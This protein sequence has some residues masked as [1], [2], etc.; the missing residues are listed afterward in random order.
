MYLVMEYIEL[1][2][3][4]TYLNEH[5]TMHES[6]TKVV[7]AQ[8]LHGIEYI[9][10][11]GISHRDLKPDNILISQMNP[12][13]IK[14]SDFGLAKMIQNENTFLKTFCG[15]MLY[16]AP[17]V[18]PAYIMLTQESRPYDG[19]EKRKRAPN[20]EAGRKISKKDRKPYNQAVDMW[21]FGC[22][23]FALLTGA[24]P[25][26]GK[27][28]DEMFKMVTEG[29]FDEQ[30]L[31]Q[32]VGQHNN[33]C[34]DF[35]RRVLQVRPE[36]RMME[37]EA[38]KHEWLRD[39]SM[40]SSQDS[41]EY[42]EDEVAGVG[43]KPS[44][45]G[46]RIPNMD[47]DDHEDY[48]DDEDVESYPQEIESHPHHETAVSSS[49][50][51]GPQ[52]NVH[53]QDSMAQMVVGKPRLLNRRST[54]SESSG[55]DDFESVINST[56][57]VS[58]GNTGLSVIDRENVFR[59]RGRLLSSIGDAG[60]M[61]DAFDA[62]HSGDD[63]QSVPG[64]DWANDYSLHGS[65]FSSIRKSALGASNLDLYKLNVQTTTAV[66]HPPDDAPVAQSSQLTTPP[67][68]S[69]HR[70]PNDSIGDQNFNANFSPESLANPSPATTP[71][72]TISVQRTIIPPH[73]ADAD[74][75]PTQPTGTS[76]LTPA[77]PWGKLHP[78]PTSLP[79]DTITL[80]GPGV[81]VGR[82]LSCAVVESDERI[83]KQ[84]I[85]I[86]MHLPHR[87]HS[88]TNPPNPLTWKPTDQMVV[89]INALSTNGV[90]LN[91]TLIKQRSAGMLCDGDEL[92]LFDDKKAKQMLGFRVE[93]GLGLVKQDDRARF[94]N[95]TAG[96]ELVAQ[97]S[98]TFGSKRE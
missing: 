48:E 4:S 88:I 56:N 60:D 36:L 11:M 18:F 21:S 24:P 96:G 39:S 49:G 26:E 37:M 23:T 2:D 16:L 83:S 43:Y 85:Q 66:G 55:Q 74:L 45:Y 33:A 61:S 10:S 75:P 54:S 68:T 90:W 62:V 64:F 5:G 58:Q 27:N 76:F 12:M 57:E 84:H 40:V 44:G 52:D 20:D 70:P 38:L 22:V 91:G 89:T 79:H 69:T 47:V 51:F 71:I 77:I 15:T 3:L 1:G 41:M 87:A 19:P 95:I 97:L 82:S 65:D 35:H 8:V 80:S 81:S 59:V 7:S 50:V 63:A 53:T 42:D 78:L 31:R 9:H 28:Q 98:A 92:V 86:Q 17:E 46:M 25:F 13:Q 32:H 72:T 34:V 30:K 93:L 67:R 73:P 94:T 14:I 29:R 6:L